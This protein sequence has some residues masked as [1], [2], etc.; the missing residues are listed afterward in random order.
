[1]RKMCGGCGV[2]L[3]PDEVGGQGALP[4]RAPGEPEFHLRLAHHPD[5]GVH[6]ARCVETCPIVEPCGDVLT[7]DEMFAEWIDHGV[8][9]G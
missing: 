5:C 3:D 6:R 7:G 4:D 8:P 1:M 9:V 2:T